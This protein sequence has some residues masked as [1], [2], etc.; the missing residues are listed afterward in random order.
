MLPNN[1]ALENQLSEKLSLRGLARALGYSVATLSEHR[2]AGIFSPLPD[3]FYDLETV[4]RRLLASTSPNTKHRVRLEPKKVA[5]RT[6]N[7]R[8]WEQWA[9]ELEAEPDVTLAPQQEA[10]V[11]A[12]MKHLRSGKFEQAINGLCDLPVEMARAMVK[13]DPEVSFAGA[14]VYFERLI[15]GNLQWAFEMMRDKNKELLK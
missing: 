2:N 12:A 9:R 4:K 7:N 3:G 5:D 15:T 10:G 1:T 6:R 14:V 8:T 13:A 11:Q